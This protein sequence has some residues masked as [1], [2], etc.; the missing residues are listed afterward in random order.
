MLTLDQ[1]F[2]F[3]DRRVAWGRMGAGDPV[4]LIHGFPWSCQAWRKV[5]PWL[6]RTHEVYWFDMAGTGASEKAPG[7]QVSEDVQS[8][9][10]A[11]LVAHWG[12][13]RPQVVGHDFGGLAALRGHFVNGLDYAKLHLFDPVAVLPSG[14]PFFAHVKQ[15]EAVFAGLP[16][17]AHEALFR[18][19][20]QNAAHLPLRPEVSDLYLAPYSGEA[21]KAAFYAQIAQSDTA[22]I[23]KAVARYQKP[24]FPVHLAWGEKDTF[25]PVARGERLRDAVGADS[26]TVIAEAAHLVQEDAPEAVLATLIRNL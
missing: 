6:A 16:D 8:D 25:I 18:A 4:I 21:G 5:A 10:L 15:H 26:F 17:Y 1:T 9:L 24:D 19:Y 12:L 22:N 11:A 2:T 3:R 7:Q 13:T 23:A 14:S 20:I